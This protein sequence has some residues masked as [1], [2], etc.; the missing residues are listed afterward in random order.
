MADVKIVDIDGEQWNIKDQDAR[1]RITVLEQKNEENTNIIESLNKNVQKGFVA[2][3]RIKKVT[4]Y[5]FET[6]F[7]S[8]FIN[9]VGPYMAIL[10]AK[11]GKV[12][13]IKDLYGSVSNY[14]SIKPLRD[15]EFELSLDGPIHIFGFVTEVS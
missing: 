1:T 5:H 7:I 8:G 2:Y 14:M 6:C 3:R 13:L 11:N 12:L 10:A 9:D 15:F 4:M